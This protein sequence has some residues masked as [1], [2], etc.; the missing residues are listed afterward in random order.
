MPFIPIIIGAVAGLIG[1]GSIAS[2]VLGVAVT[3]GLGLLSRALSPK[4]RSSS[5]GTQGRE[6]TVRHS[7]AP[8][9]IGYGIQRH[10]GVLRLVSLGGTNNEYMYLAIMVAYG[11]IESIDK[12]YFGEELA[13]T[14]TTPEAKYTS[15]LTV[16]NHLGTDTQTVST[17]LSTDLPSLVTSTD[18]AFGHA[19]TVL[20]LKWDPDVYSDFS[21]EGIRIEYHGRKVYDPRTGTTA[22]SANPVLCMRDYLTNTRFGVGVSATEIND[23][24]VKSEATYCEGLENVKAGGTE[25]RYAMHMSFT[26]EVNPAQVLDEMRKTMAGS[27]I[28]TGGLWLIQ[29]GRWRP[30]HLSLTDDDLRGPITLD[31]WSGRRAL[32]NGIKG[33]YTETTF[34]QETTYPAY[35]PASLLT[36]D[37]SYRLWT[38]MDFPGVTSASQ[39]QRLA[40]IHLNRVRK[41]KLITLPCKLKAYRLQPGDTFM[42]THARFSWTSKTFVTERV[43][44]VTEGDE[45]DLIV[46]VNIVAREEDAGVYYWNASSDETT[47]TA[48]TSPTFSDSSDVTQAPGAFVLSINGARNEGPT[49]QP[50]TADDVGASATITIASHTWRTRGRGDVT[51]NS[52]TVASLSFSTLYYVYADDSTGQGGA[53]TYAASTDRHTPYNSRIRKYIGQITTPADG[54]GGTSGGGDG[55]VIPPLIL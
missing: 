25:A 6:I 33:K 23:E 1:A 32:A 37:S 5:V 53:L 22:Y 10:G 52:G 49:S 2:V 14:G 13:A 45:N 44:L 9:T 42:F 41:Q 20:K 36:E 26:T 3:F 43:E 47:A 48:P 30:P 39:A 51:H 46:G 34:W 50:L 31:A 28:R 12:I 27:L 11:E 16:E 24:L 19:Y 18:T 35:A 38:D 15:V 55:G 8:W 29:A 40:A 54:A 21:V 7:T 17:I 4:P